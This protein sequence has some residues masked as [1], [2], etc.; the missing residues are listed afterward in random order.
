MRFLNDILERPWS[1]R[2]FLLLVTGCAGR[3]EEA[4]I[5]HHEHD[6]G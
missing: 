6:S 4:V 3:I 1:E 2:S 5:R